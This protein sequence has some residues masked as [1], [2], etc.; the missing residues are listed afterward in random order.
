[1]G[2]IWTQHFW[3]WFHGGFLFNIAVYFSIKP[4]VREI[5][6]SRTNAGVPN[7]GVDNRWS[8]KILI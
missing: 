8:V 6:G 2:R 1:M 5:D 4:D 7:D 3:A